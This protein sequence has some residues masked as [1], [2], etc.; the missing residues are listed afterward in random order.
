M[1]IPTWGKW[2]LGLF[3]VLVVVATASCLYLFQRVSNA[4]RAWTA[5][6]SVQ[7]AAPASEVEPL[8]AN[9]ERWKEWSSWRRDSD[10]EVRR[11]I[12]SLPDG[13]QRLTWGNVP[14]FQVTLGASPPIQPG[15]PKDSVGH[16]DLT[17]RAQAP[18]RYRVETRFKD[19]LAIAHRTP[20]GGGASAFT[21]DS[22]GSVFPLDGQLSVEAGADGGT[23]VTWR[24]E[25]NFGEGFAVGMLA[26]AAHEYVAEQHL[27]ALRSSLERLKQVAEKQAR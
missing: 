22:L 8:I 6:A 11:E 24:E 26:L 3:A 19:R 25:G 27:S 5:E 15:T 10:A 17:L 20:D 13:A 1:K 16:G 9:L 14:M 23:T 21:L 4:P 2:L 12:E 18:G 7:I